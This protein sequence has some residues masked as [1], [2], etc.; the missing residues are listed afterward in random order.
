MYGSFVWT[1]D[2]SVHCMQAWCLRSERASEPLGLELEMIVAYH[3]G[4]GYQTWSFA[5]ATP[6]F[7]GWVS[8][9]PIGKPTSILSVIFLLC[10]LNSSSWYGRCLKYFLYLKHH[11]FSLLNSR[12]NTYA[13]KARGCNLWAVC[14]FQRNNDYDK[15]YSVASALRSNLVC[16]S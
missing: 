12:V 1:L 15:A 2:M 9:Q 14:Q 6:T 11:F 7:H 3:V 8:A 5:R 10:W 4:A 13:W 16:Q